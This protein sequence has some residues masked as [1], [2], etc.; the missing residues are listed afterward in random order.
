MGKGDESCPVWAFAIPSEKINRFE[1]D[2]DVEAAQRSGDDIVYHAVA[3]MTTGTP[4]TSQS[5][6]TVRLDRH[7]ASTGVFPYKVTTQPQTNCDKCLVVTEA[8]AKR[9]RWKSLQPRT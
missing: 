5:V 2:G 6:Q 8:E 1:L 7:P 9:T 3:G 4:A